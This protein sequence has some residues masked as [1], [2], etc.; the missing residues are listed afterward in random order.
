MVGRALHD[1]TGLLAGEAAP[2]KQR[3]RLVGGQGR[4]VDRGDETLQER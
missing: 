3:L 1:D 2:G 4:Q